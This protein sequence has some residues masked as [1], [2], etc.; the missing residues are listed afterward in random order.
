VNDLLTKYP[1]EIQTILSRY[2]AE[3]KRSAVMPLLFLAQRDTTY[4]TRQAMQE[5]AE[6]LDISTTD[7]ASIVGFYTLFHEEPGGHYRIQICTDLPCALRGAEE[8][9]AEI[10]EYLG[11]GVGETTPDGMFTIEEVKCLA[12]CHRAP[13]FQLQGGREITYH[14]HQTLETAR[15]I[16]EE[17]K[18]RTY[19]VEEETTK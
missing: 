6:I 18:Q 16:F 7:V 15:A 9:M 17:L 10:C 1:E 3:Q 14:E 8:F 2:P 4:V 19:P 11:I 12:A 5:I 13:M